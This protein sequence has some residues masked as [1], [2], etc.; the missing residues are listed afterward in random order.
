MTNN[1]F[2]SWEIS[3]KEDS[4]GHNAEVW[5]VVIARGFH[6]N[7]VS[8]GKSVCLSFYRVSRRRKNPRS[9][10]ACGSL[11]GNHVINDGAIKGMDFIGLEH[12]SL[13]F[14]TLVVGFLPCGLRI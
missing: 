8:Q 4:T 10:R 12:G 1:R 3:R 6:S 9:V 11:L 7:V 5:K 2:S 13:V 14:H